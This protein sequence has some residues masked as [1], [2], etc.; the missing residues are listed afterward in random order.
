[1][2]TRNPIHAVVHHDDMWVVVTP[3]K[4]VDS[5]GLIRLLAVA[6]GLP[7]WDA[8]D[9]IR[10]WLARGLLEASPHELL[11][12]S[13][14]RADLRLDRRF[15]ILGCEK[16]GFCKAGVVACH[17][18][19]SPTADLVVVVGVKPTTALHIPFA[20]QS[21]IPFARILDLRSGDECGP[22]LNQGFGRLSGEEL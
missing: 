8:V 19:D 21:V 2:F 16:R 5:L 6:E 22:F 13:I 4:V 12:V 9:S 15:C 3:P 1:M 11:D 20:Q 17:F 7:V 10:V 18:I 14:E